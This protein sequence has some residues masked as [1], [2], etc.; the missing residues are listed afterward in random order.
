MKTWPGCVLEHSD[1]ICLDATSLQSYLVLSSAN[2]LIDATSDSF[3]PFRPILRKNSVVFVANMNN[4]ARFSWC[5]YYIEENGK[6]EAFWLTPT[7]EVLRPDQ[8][9]YSNTYHVGPNMTY[10]YLRISGQTHIYVVFE[11]LRCL[12]WNSQQSSKNPCRGRMG[13]T[14]GLSACAKLI[15]VLTGGEC[16]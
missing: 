10:L 5:R 3:Q 8:S 12:L 2:P 7:W 14:T 6:R 11:V 1:N 9:T 15:E 16:K 13:R 4:L